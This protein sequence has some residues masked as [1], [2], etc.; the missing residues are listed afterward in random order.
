MLR[1]WGGVPIENTAVSFAEDVQL[2]ARAKEEDVL[3][4]IYTDAKLASSLMTWDQ[5]VQYRKARA[6][7]GAALALLA[8]AYAWQNDYNNALLYTDSLINK[9]NGLYDLEDA[10]NLRRFFSESTSKE[11]IF[12][13]TTLNSNNEASFSGSIGF[14]TLQ[15][16]YIQG[17]NAIPQYTFN[18]DA[19]QIYYS[20]SNDARLSAF[21]GLPN[22]IE[23]IL[24]K[25]SDV[26]YR[27]PVQMLEP[28]VES[29]VVIFRLA[30]IVLLQAE[31]LAALNRDDEARASLNT[32]RSRAG[33]DPFTGSGQL[34]QR[35]ILQERIRELV[36]E[37]HNYF[38][39]VRT[40]S[41]PTW[42]TP[43]RLELK[44]WLWPI[45]TS[46]FSN[47]SL[48]EQNEYWRGKYASLN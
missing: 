42:M 48:L 10:G 35:E 12:A 44:G 31:A 15:H 7:K 26:K 24:I 5:A 29:N 39:M 23:P 33:I 4:Q 17:F 14:V 25:Y 47:N 32:I 43:A 40:K 45:H 46:F 22:N 1:I 37:G 36:G 11:N 27:N 19:L 28:F 8:H 6:S 3:Q 38:D 20:N 16:P 18:K 9:S 2:H 21:V 41:Y 13:L 34:L 30:D